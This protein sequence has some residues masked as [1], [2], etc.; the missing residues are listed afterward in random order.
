MLVDIHEQNHS[1]RKSNRIVDQP[2]DC[3]LYPLTFYC[4][5]IRR[6]TR[7]DI[8]LTRSFSCSIHWPVVFFKQK[9]TDFLDRTMLRKSFY[10]GVF[11]DRRGSSVGFCW[12]RK[13]ICLFFLNFQSIDSYARMWT[14]D[15]SLRTRHYTKN[16]FLLFDLRLCAQNT[17]SPPPVYFRKNFLFWYVLE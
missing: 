8:D 14:I 9:R 5:E 11:G 4:S 17:T 6:D 13:E 15:R 2:A 1:N 3:I 7:F 16:G 10:S 12:N